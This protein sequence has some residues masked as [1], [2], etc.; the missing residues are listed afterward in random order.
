MSDDTQNLRE[1]IEDIEVL[2]FRQ[3]ADG[4]FDKGDRITSQVF[5]LYP[6]DDGL[7]STARSSATSTPDAQSAFKAFI[8]DIE[9]AESEGVIA[10]SVDDVIKV[11][12]KGP[13]GEEEAKL[14]A[15]NDG[16]CIVL[17]ADG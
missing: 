5:A 1:E 6:K 11:K 2:L 9:G 12:V 7:I 8:E 17:S 3:V 16:K 13:E 4:W 15:W 10:V 14:R